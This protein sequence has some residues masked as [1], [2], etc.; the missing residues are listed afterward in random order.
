MDLTLTLSVYEPV[1]VG[2]S[3]LAT[4]VVANEGPSAIPAV[5]ARLNLMEGDLRISAQGP[6]GTTTE[7]RG[8]QADTTLKQVSLKPG[9][10]IEGS[11]NLAWSEAGATFPIP[12]NYV[13]RAEYDPSPRMEAV[14]SDPVSVTARLP[15]TAEERSARALLTESHVAEAIATGRSDLAASALEML[16]RDAAE[17]LDGQLARLLVGGIKA[18]D[19]ASGGADT[20]TSEGLATRARQVI[21]LSGPYSSVGGRLSEELLRDIRSR[22]VVDSGAEAAIRIIEG[23]PHEDAD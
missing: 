3:V 1:V 11:F 16:A 17:T 5:S 21:A 23:T 20:L 6:Q 15:E 7:V 9:E 2:L 8:W 19:P 4:V 14:V 12:G 10:Q 18:A 13:L 22:D